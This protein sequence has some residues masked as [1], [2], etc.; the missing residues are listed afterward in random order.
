[1]HM[2]IFKLSAHSLVYLLPVRNNFENLYKLI[3][4]FLNIFILFLLPFNLNFQ[5]I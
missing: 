4:S 1:M 2:R 5:N 3:F